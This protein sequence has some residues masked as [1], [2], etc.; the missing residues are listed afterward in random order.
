MQGSQTAGADL[1]P[2]S[3]PVNG[4]GQLLDVG[5]EAGFGMPLGVAHVVSRNPNLVAN[6]TFH[7]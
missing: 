2:P 4:Q 7:G 6:F 5:Q 3:G 1:N